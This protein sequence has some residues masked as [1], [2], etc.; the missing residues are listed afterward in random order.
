MYSEMMWKARKDHAE[1]RKKPA[2]DS[3]KLSLYKAKDEGAMNI[4]ALL[5][6]EENSLTTGFGCQWEQLQYNPA[7]DKWEPVPGTQKN[8]PVPH[9]LPT[10]VE[11]YKP[12]FETFKTDIV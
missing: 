9:T 8:V 6:Y 3:A 7:T 11:H 10:A 12:V 1:E 2:P 4:L 5:T